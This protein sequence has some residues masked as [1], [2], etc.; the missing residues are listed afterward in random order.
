MHRSSVFFRFLAA[1]MLV[2][3]SGAEARSEAP[4]VAP[5]SVFA[6]N[7]T[8]E[9]LE[10]IGE[11]FRRKTGTPV[12]VTGG[13]SP[14]L[15][16]KILS[17][18][19]ADL[20]VAASRGVL[21]DLLRKGMVNEDSSFLWATN[22]LVVVV[23]SGTEPPRSPQEIAADRFRR[24]AFPDPEATVVGPFVRQ[25]LTTAGVWETVRPRMVPTEDDEKALALLE[26]GEADLAIVYAT[27]ARRHS[28]ARAALSLPRDSHQTIPYPVVLVAHPGASP[29]ARPFLDFL[30]SPQV[31]TLLE[32]AGFTPAF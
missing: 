32:E 15:A 1:A 17:G 22:S 31:R 20:F 3:G 16:A 24:V 13:G 4:A 6:A 23:P 9:V 26:T 14:A 5:V 27:D 21:A 8:V 19:N 12:Q 29:H 28:G 7:G 25:A 30:R 2:L 11:A 10:K 18:A